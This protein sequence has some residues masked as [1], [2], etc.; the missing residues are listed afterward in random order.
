[1][2][3]F[4]EALTL[5]LGKAVFSG[6]EFVPMMESVGRVLAQDVLSDMDMPPF[7]KSAV[8]GFAIAMDNAYEKSNHGGHYRII[9][10]IPAGKVPL[11]G[12]HPG[13]CS[14]IMT[15]AMVP[16]GTA[17]IVMVEDTEIS[18]DGMMH[19]RSEKNAANIC[20]RGEDIR[21]G[22][23]VMP[24][25]TLLAP[26]HIAVLASTG[27]VKPLVARRPSVGIIATG[28]ELVEPGIIPGTAQIRNSNSSQL[29]S[30]VAQAGAMGTDLGIA[31]DS[32]ESLSNMINKALEEHDIVLLTGGVS[33][34]D[35]D[36]VP[37]MME[38]A[39]VDIHFRTI[40]IQP[41]KPT[42]FGTREGKYIFGL[43]GNPVSSFVLFEVMV[44]PFIRRI[45]GWKG[46]TPA[47][48]MPMGA[49]YWRKRSNRLSFV[50]VRISNGEI[51]PVEYHGS[52]HINAYTVADGMISIGIG[53]TGIHKGTLTDVRPI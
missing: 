4:D 37:A 8:D 28:D 24:A 10:T 33:M 21:R 11:S 27:I 34:G 50:P 22:D 45:M 29:V 25:G 47:L 43:P 14:K 31:A 12:L 5:V 15:G 46:E 18:G 40:A 48:R 30:Q 49:D 52:A 23:I 53:E 32:E 2:I 42:V 41:G 19:I 6:A 39:G 44:K 7:D 13:E 38:K 17:R 36:H 20:M 26:Q 9:E 35:F 1:M 51:F 3:L 16:K